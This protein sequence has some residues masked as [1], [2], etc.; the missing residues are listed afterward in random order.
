MTI[1]AMWPLTG[2]VSPHKTIDTVGGIT[3]I[4]TTRSIALHVTTDT[5]SPAMTGGGLREMIGTT[6][7]T[8]TGVTPHKTIGT[9]RFTTIEM[10][11]HDTMNTTRLTTIEV[12]LRD[13]IDMMRERVI[14]NLHEKRRIEESN[15]P[16]APEL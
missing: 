5:M 14:P 10:N 3:T 12:S 2:G 1:D 16:L 15:S 9:M 11:F 13:R 8:V 4:T 6:R 7:V